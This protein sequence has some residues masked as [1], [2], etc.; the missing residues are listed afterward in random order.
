M[1]AITITNGAHVGVGGTPAGFGQAANAG[2]DTFQNDGNTLLWVYNGGTSSIT[3]TVT[4][5]SAGPWDDTPKNETITV[6]A[7]EWRLAGPFAPQ[8]FNNTNGQVALSYS[9]V[10]SVVVGAIKL[11]DPLKGTVS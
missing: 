1:A 5:Q 11:P 3:V 2:G 8:R 10:T 9:G 4:A 7:G 6:P